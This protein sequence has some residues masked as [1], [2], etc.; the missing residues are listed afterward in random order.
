MWGDSPE[1]LEAYFEHEREHRTS[2][3]YVDI[4]HW[5]DEGGRYE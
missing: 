1:E 5:E 2:Y 3:L 4:D